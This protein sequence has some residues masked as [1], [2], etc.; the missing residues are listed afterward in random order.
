MRMDK[1]WGGSPDKDIAILKQGRYRML[2]TQIYQNINH[3]SQELFIALDRV[4]SEEGSME[5]L[6]NFYSTFK[7]FNDDVNSYLNKIPQDG[8]ITGEV[9]IIDHV[10][11]AVNYRM[12]LSSYQAAKGEYNVDVLNK[13]KAEL[14]DLIMWLQL[15]T[16]GLPTDMVA[17]TVFVQFP[18]TVALDKGVIIQGSYETMR[19]AVI[20]QRTLQQNI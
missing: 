8:N 11:N 1:D 20:N 10:R 6:S 13:E 17:A 2:W 4:E 7:E 3:L 9:P 12:T 19:N 14:E 5:A 15:M 16:F 18:N